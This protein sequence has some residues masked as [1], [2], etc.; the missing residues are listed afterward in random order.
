MGQT[1]LINRI[2][3]SLS[4]YFYSKAEYRANWADNGDASGPN[5][6]DCYSQSLQRMAEYVAD[7]PDDDPRLQ[8]LAG[9]PELFSTDVFSPA[10]PNDYSRADEDGMH[11]GPRGS[12]IGAE[13]CGEWFSDW[14]RT[15]IRE[16][17][18]EVRAREEHGE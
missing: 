6:N 9:F 4:E 18:K 7:L 1:Q 2:R 15:V 5:K 8:Q 16:A 11:C 13:K 12:V 3:A 17:E 14:T 10:R